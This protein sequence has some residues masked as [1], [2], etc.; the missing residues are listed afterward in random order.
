MT[1]SCQEGSPG[2]NLS[3]PFY[4]IPLGLVV[5]I[6]KSLSEA[7]GME[8]ASLPKRR[9][10]QKDVLLWEHFVECMDHLES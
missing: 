10:E 9:N 1:L 8:Q 6:I 5:S 7:L 3:A 4:Q 2:L